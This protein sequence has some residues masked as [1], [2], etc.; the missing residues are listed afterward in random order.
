[1]KSNVLVILLALSIGVNVYLALELEHAQQAL[2]VAE[3]AAT[4]TD[5][6]PQETI[7]Q[8]GETYPFL[9]VVDGDTVTVGIGG[10]A[11]YVRLIGIDAPE[12]NDVGGPECYADESTAHL[13]E[14]LSTGT[15]RLV[16]DASQG[17]RD[18]YNRLLAYVE[19][20]DGTDVGLSM[21]LNGYAREY[22]YDAPYV[23]RDAYLEAETDAAR[24]GRGLW[25]ESTCN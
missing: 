21:L 25:S 17:L 8:S 20:P 13:V 6:Q 11:E 15:V 12:P 24:E 14:L 16:F 5:S 9:R 22:L 19:L 7:Y 10:R 23:R 4:A 2:V 1:M 18:K 3:T